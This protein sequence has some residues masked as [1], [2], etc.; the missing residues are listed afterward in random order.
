MLIIKKLPFIDP[1]ASIMTECFLLGVSV[2]MNMKPFTYK[3]E[4]K[5]CLLHH[6]KADVKYEYSRTALSSQV[7]LSL[8]VENAFDP[9]RLYNQSLYCFVSD[10][11]SKTT[12]YFEHPHSHTSGTPDQDTLFS[13]MDDRRFGTRFSSSLVNGQTEDVRKLIHNIEDFFKNEKGQPDGYC[14]EIG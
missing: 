5:W 7:E 6:V 1:D 11:G 14:L 8:H 13:D 3:N 4:H 9:N 10:P 12:F 2:L